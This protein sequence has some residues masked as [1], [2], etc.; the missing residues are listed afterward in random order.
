MCDQ[1][2]PFLGF[3][4][5]WSDSFPFHLRHSLDTHCIFGDNN[6]SSLVMR[7]LSADGWV[8]FIYK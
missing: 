4:V 2:V 8:W 5:R 7:D 1:V 3:P 6:I